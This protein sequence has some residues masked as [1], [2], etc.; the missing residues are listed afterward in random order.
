LIL[1]PKQM[2]RF[3]IAGGYFAIAGKT[4]PLQ[5]WMWG[6]IAEQGVHPRSDAPY[7]KYRWMLENAQSVDRSTSP[8]F[9]GLWW[10]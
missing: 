5:H 3:G 2:C 10:M 7:V 6:A 9:T 1:I 4:M 8:C